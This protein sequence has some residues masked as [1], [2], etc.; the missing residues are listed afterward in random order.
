MVG[1]FPRSSLV[2]FGGDFSPYFGFPVE[3]ADGIESLFAG[4]SSSEDDDLVG[5]GIIVDGA[6]GAMG[7]S[8][9]GGVDFGPGFVGGVVG[10]EIVHVVGV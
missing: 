7:G 10:P 9:S 8:L 2:F 5:G 6:V 4:S 1:S 3:N